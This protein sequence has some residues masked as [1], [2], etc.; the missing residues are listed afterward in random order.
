M[1][2]TRTFQTI[3]TKDFSEHADCY[4]L[5]FYGSTFGNKDH[6]DDVIVKGAFSETITKRTPKL[7]WGHD[8][9]EV[10]IGRITEMK[11][12]EKGLR[13]KAILPKEDELVK[14][15]I[16]PQLRIGALDGV[17]IGFRIK[18]RTYEKGIRY[19]KSVDLFEISLVNLPCN[20]M[21]TVQGFKSIDGALPYADLPLAKLDRKWDAE[22]AEKRIKEFLETASDSAVK[23]SDCYL[24]R[25]ETSG[26]EASSYKYLIADV[27][28]T[29]S[30]DDVKTRIAAVP[31]AIFKAASAIMGSKGA[32]GITP[33]A[34]DA[35]Q[36]H[37]DRYYDR[38]D[39]QSPTKALAKCEFDA[40]EAGEREARLRALGCSGSLAK[41]LS[42]PRD[43]GRSQRDA[44]G[45]SSASEMRALLAALKQTTLEIT[46]NDR[47]D[48]GD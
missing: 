24:Y 16:A 5:E 29:G 48:R 32:E 34:R 7:L 2:I 11:E 3:E 17:S 9:S 21:A 36:D 40:L 33:E 31:A 35:L 47:P 12:D 27:V 41:S 20:E 8:T 46:K 23:M 19:I 28:E 10:C 18:E 38:L 45:D 25:D 44:G 15:R 42:G 22:A 26:G 6:D 14:G 37:L 43:A 13:C 4:T 1:T 39:L 30:G